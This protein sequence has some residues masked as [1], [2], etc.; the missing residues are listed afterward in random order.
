MPG[1]NLLFLQMLVVL[2]AVRLVS[3]V[4]RFF[5]QP[6]VVGEMAAGLL[7]G[8]SFLGRI[9]PAAMSYLFPPG[10]LGPLYAVSQVGLVLFMF[11][12]G[13]EGRP[14]ALRGSAR[15]AV[16][17]SQASILAP[18]ALGAILAWAIYPQLGSGAARLPF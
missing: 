9:S 2:L 7:L 5:R 1:L 16:L 18:F 13:L 4:F 15:W 3:A 17:A 12:V 10:G 14:A 6:G 11:L 8:P